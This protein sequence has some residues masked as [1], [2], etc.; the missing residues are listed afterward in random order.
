MVILSKLDL[1]QD[2]EEEIKSKKQEIVQ[3]INDFELEGRA[4][5]FEKL[6]LTKNSSDKDIQ[7]L[8]NEIYEIIMSQP[9][10]I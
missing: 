9:Q 7:E 6:I 5:L 1:S 10:S 8:E 4:T 3:K 2:T